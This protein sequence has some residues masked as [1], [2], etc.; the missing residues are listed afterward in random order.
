MQPTSTNGHPNSA[1]EA[2]DTV[3]Q[4]VEKLEADLQKQQEEIKQLRSERDQARAMFNEM[5]RFIRQLP[6][7]EQFDP[8][9]YTC[10]LDDILADIRAK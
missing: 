6:E 9:E 10:T 7:W 1:R 8:K 2:L 4:L 5:K 3:R